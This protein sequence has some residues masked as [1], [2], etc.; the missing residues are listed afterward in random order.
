MKS[1]IKCCLFSFL[2][3]NSLAF[4]QSE[5]F[6]YTREINGISGQ[7]HKIVLPDSVFSKVAPDFRDIRILG[8]TKS[9]DTIEAPYLLR[10]ASG[11]IS[12]TEI[13]FDIINT[14]H[15]ERGYFYTFELA[16]ENPVNQ[17][18][19]EFNQQNFDWNIALE[20]SQ[21][22]QEWFTILKG[23]R[24]MSIQNGLTD[25]HFTRLV[26]PN[27]RYRFFRLRIPSRADP[28]L[29]LATISERILADGTFRTY[30]IQ[31]FQA[32]EDKQ[33]KQRKIDFTLPMPI[34]LSRLRI[35]VRDTIDYYRPVS[36]RFRSDSIKTAEGWNY[37]YTTL[38]SGTLNSLE[39]NSFDFNSRI[40]QHLSIIIENQDNRPLTIDSITAQSNVHEL[41][42][43][44]TEPAQY[45]LAYGNERAGRPQY[46][47][48]RFSDKI[49]E[50]LTPLELGYERGAGQVDQVAK[51]PF[52]NKAWLWAVMVVIMLVLGWFTV[53]LMQKQP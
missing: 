5:Q 18:Y 36:I 37:R 13:D 53:R 31:N 23:Y 33:K 39:E 34:P 7:W 47:I 17:I 40:C 44:F 16:T 29:Q 3:A 51:A 28:E 19:L 43:R 12:D 32:E 6:K 52:F 25:F 11:K 42:A 45:F 20:G 38:N 30:P 1:K 50:E 27:A 21:N 26:F 35:A 2:I 4:G 41:I 9:G 24:I 10:V 8:I 22:Q 15:N 49:P 46:D 14:A 48:G